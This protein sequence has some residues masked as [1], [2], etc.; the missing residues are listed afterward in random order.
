MSSN[1]IQYSKSKLTYQEVVFLFYE[2]TGDDGE[3]RR[4]ICTTI[5]AVVSNDRL[6]WSSVFKK[7]KYEER[8]L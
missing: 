8:K 6:L 3:Q 4:I 1:T 5:I 7:R 2:L